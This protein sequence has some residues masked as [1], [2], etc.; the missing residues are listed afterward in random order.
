MKGW[1]HGLDSS[2]CLPAFI[3]LLLGT[4]CS[5]LPCQTQ[6]CAGMPCR[7]VCNV[8]ACALNPAH[9]SKLS[10]VFAEQ[11]RRLIQQ[12]RSACAACAACAACTA[13][14]SMCMARLLPLS[15][16]PCWRVRQRP[17]KPS[18]AGD[19]EWGWPLVSALSH[20]L[21]TH[22]L[23][24]GRRRHRRPDVT[25]RAV[26]RAAGHGWRFQ[27]S[28]QGP[29]PG[30]HGS[31]QRRRPAGQLHR[32]GQPPA[33]RAVPAG[34]AGARSCAG[35]LRS[36]WR[37]HAP[38][39]NLCTQIYRTPTCGHGVPGCA[40]L[41]TC[42]RRSFFC[43][44]VFKYAPLAHQPCCCSAGR[45]AS[46]PGAN[47]APRPA[48]AGCARPAPRHACGPQ[49]RARHRGGAV[50]R[51]SCQPHPMHCPLHRCARGPPKPP[52]CMPSLSR[53]TGLG[54]PPDCRTGHASHPAAA[55]AAPPSP[56]GSSVYPEKKK[57]VDDYVSIPRSCTA[58]ARPAA[59]LRALP[60]SACAA[61]WPL[62]CRRR[63]CS[64]LLAALARR[65]GSEPSS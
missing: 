25:G 53:H 21:G 4:V 11:R 32:A 26:R 22:S 39:S 62:S 58:R 37:R 30:G 17:T 20:S 57:V 35:C 19:V 40:G 48:A 44:P 13:A 38:L 65:P 49:H 46:C 7:A 24:A 5:S 3:Q 56:I 29:L 50:G 2:G 6:A 47:P 43:S 45:A 12:A 23:P 10:P 34:C 1:R 33:G 9:R 55:Q 16:R 31:R 14:Q 52:S 28:L 51:P 59:S 64:R 27:R 41:H 42:S 8:R 60:P 63:P 61:A 54:D 18:R 15:S 36:L